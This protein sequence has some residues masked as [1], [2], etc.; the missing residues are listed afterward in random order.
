MATTRIHMGT[1]TR[2][3]GIKGE[4]CVDWYADSPELL[5]NTFFLQVGSEP[6]REISGAKIRMHKGRP[7][8]TLP[9]VQDR[10]QAEALRGFRIYVDRSHM[11]NLE[12]DEVYLHDII[13]FTVVHAETEK[14]I[15][16]LD[17]LEFPTDEQ[18]LWSIKAVGG[19]EILFPAVEEFIHSFDMPGERVLILPPEG[20]LELYLE[21]K[22]EK[23]V[24]K[25]QGSRPRKKASEASTASSKKQNSNTETSAK[26]EQRS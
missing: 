6:M 5:R 1:I 19:Q 9:H 20:L 17:G 25:P 4:I 7:L 8:L 12:D 26:K 14:D 13:G 15:G 21:E 10:T 23:P 24:K 22:P 3:H 11:P 18:M 2:P 16:I